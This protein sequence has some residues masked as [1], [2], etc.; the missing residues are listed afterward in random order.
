MFSSLIALNKLFLNYLSQVM[1][2]DL[3]PAT[4]A[5][6]TQSLSFTANGLVVKVN[7]YS[8]KEVMK[9]YLTL[10]LQGQYCYHCCGVYLCDLI[11]PRMLKNKLTCKSIVAVAVIQCK[12]SIL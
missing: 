7:G 1:A 3:Y 5:G 8:D 4:L 10:L 6:Y 12:Y 2:S 11:S 9:Q